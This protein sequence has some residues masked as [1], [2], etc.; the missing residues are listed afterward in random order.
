MA[1]FPMTSQ[2]SSTLLCF[3]TSSNVNSFSGSGAMVN[4]Y[5]VGLDLVCSGWSG[6]VVFVA[7]VLVRLWL[8]AEEAMT[9]LLAANTRT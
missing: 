7:C 1:S 9:C 5:D 4:Y 8:R 3:E 2:Q 6:R